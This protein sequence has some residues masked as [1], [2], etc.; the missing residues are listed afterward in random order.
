MGGSVGLRLLR[1]SRDPTNRKA[2]AV[3]LAA[4]IVVVMAL[5]PATGFA[6]DPIRFDV[7]VAK[8]SSIG[9][10]P[11]I[12]PRGAALHHALEEQFKYDR[13]EVIATTVFVLGIDEVGRT[14]LPNGREL[15]I[16]PLV[17]DAAGALVAVDVRG[18]LKTDLRMKNDH[19]VVIGAER[20]EGGKLVIS[21]EPH[22]GN[23]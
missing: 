4:S 23:P 6:A 1:S 12:D 22:F 11:V 5:C 15:L 7:L 3:A 16:K 2:G 14:N 13:L 17:I 10:E 8:V 21:L 9:G 20:F 19:L 18:L